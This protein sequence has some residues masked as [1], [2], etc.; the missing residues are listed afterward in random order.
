MSSNVTKGS[1]VQDLVPGS[2]YKRGDVIGQKYEVYDVLGSTGLGVAYLVFS[3]EAR[4][5]YVLKTFREEYLADAKARQRFRDEASAWV[6]VGRHPYLVHA[7]FVINVGGQLF[8]GME[9]VAPTTAD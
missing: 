6:A 2:S 1:E 7:H 3:H 5:V 4:E 8:V 9:H